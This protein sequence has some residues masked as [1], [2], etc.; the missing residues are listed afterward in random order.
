MSTV[1]IVE[2][3]TPETH[4]LRGL[5]LRDGTPSHDVSFV[6]DDLDGTFHLGSVVDGRV[7]A[8]STW[9]PEPWEGAP[10]VPAIRLRGMAVEPTFQGSGVGARLLEAGLARC[11][12]SGVHIVWAAARDTAL[13]FY[14]RFGFAIVGDGFVDAATALSHH[15]VMRRL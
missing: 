12:A 4:E 7:V 8:T 6:Q 13:P 1:E 14:E 10:F 3:T 9:A 2:L 5:V 15:L 11:R